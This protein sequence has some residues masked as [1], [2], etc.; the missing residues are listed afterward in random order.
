MLWVYTYMRNITLIWEY[1]EHHQ[2]LSSLAANAIV[3]LVGILIGRRTEKSNSIRELK[4]LASV[5]KNSVIDR[6]E[7]LLYALNRS[8]DANI[9]RVESIIAGDDKYV[10]ERL[11]LTLLESTATMKYGVLQDLPL[12]YAIDATR[13]SMQITDHALALKESGVYPMPLNAVHD[14]QGY[15]KRIGQRRDLTNSALRGLLDLLTN[16]QSQLASAHAACKS[17]RMALARKNKS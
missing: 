8:I 3:L 5:E 12:C 14:G 11:D 13:S 2:F 7:D 6:K 17:E 15:P 16:L 10:A 1:L 9:S 4:R